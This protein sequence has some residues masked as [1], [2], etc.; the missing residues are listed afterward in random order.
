MA[1]LRITVA[2]QAELLEALAAGREDDDSVD[3]RG[4]IDASDTGRRQA[5][6]VLN[7]YILRKTREERER[8]AMR[9]S[10]LAAEPMQ[11]QETQVQEA[12]RSLPAV[13]RDNT[14]PTLQRLP[15]EP[16]QEASRSRLFSFLRSSSTVEPR[17]V[18]A[19]RPAPTTVQ[20]DEALVTPL[21]SRTLTGITLVNNG[22]RRTTGRRTSSPQRRSTASTNSYLQ[23]SP[24]SNITSEST[25]P[26]SA[27][28]SESFLGTPSITSYGGCCKYAHHLRD[29]KV[30]KS[31]GR[32]NLA[33][34]PGAINFN[35]RCQSTKCT[36]QIP[37]YQNKK[38]DWVID[39]RPRMWRRKLQYT[40]IFL[41]KSHIPTLV[42]LLEQPTNAQYRCI[43]CILS[44]ERASV[45]HGHNALLEHVFG[46]G[47][48]M[49]DS[50]KLEGPLSFSNDGVSI[51]SKFDIN[52]PEREPNITTQMATP[53]HTSDT[54]ADA[55]LQHELEKLEIRSK[56]S[57]HASQEMDPYFS[58]W[59]D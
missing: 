25:S 37:S 46:H 34:S 26:R 56:R 32:Q 31:L 6:V 12:G 52:L 57:S 29:G 15:S 59:A 2:T 22:G 30:N 58:P 47:G 35:F 1:M 33:V 51:S 45:F 21:Q 24:G 43:I 7:E 4:C 3:F 54:V 42:P 5:L 55:E 41:A 23:M 48:A 28:I 8:V 18:Q 20:S 14:M 27:S 16:A 53:M 17:P 36:F 44:H 38:H 40:L 39:D 50:V 9:K 11:R 49:L 13:Q 10:E 19:T